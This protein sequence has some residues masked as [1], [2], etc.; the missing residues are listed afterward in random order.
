MNCYIKVI[1]IT[2]NMPYNNMNLRHRRT[3]YGFKKLVICTC[4]GFIG[5][6]Y[7]SYCQKPS[8]IIDLYYTNQ[9]FLEYLVKSGIDSI[10]RQ[11]RLPFLYNDSICYLAANDHAQYL[12]DFEEIM[13]FQ[14]DSSKKTPQER[15]E[16]YGAKGYIAGENIVKIFLHTPFS[17]RV[18]VSK[19]NTMAVSTYQEAAQF[20]VNAWVNSAEHFINILSKDYDVTGV[21]AI[22]NEDEKS[23]ICVQVFAEVDTSYHFKSWPSVFPYDNLVHE[24]EIPSA[25]SDPEN[26]SCEKKRKWNIGYPS[27]EE[28]ITLLNKLIGSSPKWNII[29]KGNDVYLNMGKTESALKL[30]NNKYDGLALEIVPFHVYYCNSSSGSMSSTQ[31]TENCIFNSEITKPVY[32]DRLFRKKLDPPK[33][34]EEHDLFIP[35][36]GRIPDNITEPYEVNVLFLKNNKI[37]KL[38]QSHHLCGQIPDH[39]TKVP[40]YIYDTVPYENYK[41]NPAYMINTIDIRSL[42][43]GD[44]VNFYDNPVPDSDS[45]AVTEYLKLFS[46]IPVAGQSEDYP[47]RLFNLIYARM[48]SIQNYLFSRFLENKIEFHIIEKLP[49]LITDHEGYF[50]RSQP[51]SQLYYDRMI[52]KYRHIK[53]ELPDTEFLRIN[54]TM[55]NFRNP[56]PVAHYNYYALLVRYMDEN[57]TQSISLA[58]LREISSILRRIEGR[59]PQAY[60]DSLS[61]FYH[62]Q[63]VLKYYSDG[64]FDYRRM[65]SSLEYIHH[66]YE[67]HYLSPESRVILARFFIHFRLY[68]F[69]F[70]SILPAAGLNPYYKEAYILYLKIYYSGL[71][72]QENTTGYY[73]QILNASSVLSTEEWL[74]LF[75]GPCRINFQLLDYEPLRD[76][77]CAKRRSLQLKN[78]DKATSWVFF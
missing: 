72:K 74:G 69:A 53:D 37:Y 47:G 55:K 41:Y 48:D 10:R 22:V 26:I 71:V 77:Y 63:R 20:V 2:S 59:I 65:Y 68:D 30:F 60:F 11:N 8:D 6:S 42:P 15:V 1:L 54:E 19:P 29:Y 40:L 32:L 75:E 12:M 24:Q 56:L 18:G 50:H 62:S 28:E 67:T 78:P 45:L 76:L 43:Y 66:Y 36:A 49:A 51:L 21:A 34:D 4:L 61:I 38:I 23:L 52:F 46:L 70:E 35:Y 17:Y 73:E 25:S 16:Y 9:A 33:D 5:T 44:T 58:N 13:H 14:S 57:I 27:D 3:G 31:E 39:L 7:L 64:M